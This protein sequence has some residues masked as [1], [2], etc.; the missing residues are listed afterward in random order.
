MFSNLNSITNRA[1]LVLQGQDRAKKHTY[2]FGV[3]YQFAETN[4][5]DYYDQDGDFQPHWYNYFDYNYQDSFRTGFENN[6]RKTFNI[7][8][9]QANITELSLRM[10]SYKILDITD[11]FSVTPDLNSSFSWASNYRRNILGEDG[12]YH[13]ED[14]GSGFNFG[15]SP[16]LSIGYET[17]ISDVAI[18]MYANFKIDYSIGNTY[19]SE[20]YDSDFNYSISAKFSLEYQKP[21]SDTKVDVYTDFKI[22]Y[23][24]QDPNLRAI[25][26]DNHLESDTYLAF[27]NT[28]HINLEKDFFN[29]TWSANI[30]LSSHLGYHSEFSSRLSGN[31]SIARKNIDNWYFNLSTDLSSADYGFPANSKRF[32][33]NFV[34]RI[35]AG[36]MGL[37][38]DLNLGY[39]DREGV[40]S[41][42]DEEGQ[43]IQEDTDSSSFNFNLGLDSF[44]AFND[45]V[46]ARA[47]LTTSG[48]FGVTPASY[49]YL[50]N[51]DLE[52]I[53]ASRNEA[54]TS[55]TSFSIH[56]YTIENWKI[57]AHYSHPITWFDNSKDNSLDRN[58]LSY[59]EFDQHYYSS[60][61]VPQFSIT[62][63][64]NH[65]PFS[66]AKQ[67]FYSGITLGLYDPFSLQKFY[68]TTYFS[69][70]LNYPNQDS[71]TLNA[72]FNEPNH[73]SSRVGISYHSDP[74]GL[75]TWDGKFG[76]EDLTFDLG[77]DYDFTQE[78]I[79]AYGRAYIDT[80]I[81]YDLNLGFN[82]EVGY[83]NGEWSLSFY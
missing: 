50:E 42:V 71:I 10:S 21:I 25:E 17:N 6:Y 15:I 37:D 45:L 55:Y 16:Q 41:Y 29:D 70:N 68:A 69:Y 23:A 58:N 43:E 66:A 18:N 67:R 2:N 22:D 82:V 8:F 5:Y 4:S 40:L 81:S 28:S 56:T 59:N 63:D 51:G 34:H 76:I 38:T 52:E 19:R 27:S 78:E 12:E 79:Y 33:M 11:N 64:S 74:F 80:V 48:N 62:L 46:Q 24:N 36:M 61:S 77:I 54:M 30:G 9:S 49:Y 1:G 75:V 44:Y 26:L 72:N 32:S 73:S 57:S 20:G 14:Y 35:D 60:S 7:R 53:S 13:V 47:L 39:N 3:G 83:R 65:S 31:A